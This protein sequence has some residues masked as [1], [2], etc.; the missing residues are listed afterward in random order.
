MRRTG[1]RFAYTDVFSGIVSVPAELFEAAG[2]FDV[3]LD[4]CRDD[5]EL[6]LRLIRGGAEIVF[7]D[8]AGGWHHELRDHERL[9]RRKR[10]EGVADLRL[11]RRHPS[12]WPAL[13]IAW[14]EPP[15]LSRLGVMRRLALDAPL[16]GDLAARA[17]AA[18]LSPLERIRAH[19]TWRSAHAGVM[20]Y[21]Y[22]RGVAQDVGSRGALAELGAWCAAQPS[23]APREIALDLSRGL[24]AAE[25]RLDA[26]RPDGARILWGER[27]IGRIAPRPDAE[28]LRGAHLR[29]IL[30]VEHR[31]R[32]IRELVAAEA[33]GEASA[34]TRPA[35]TRSAVPPG[36]VVTTVAGGPDG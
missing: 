24:D 15:L 23:A 30:W 22:W 4:N 8:D 20:Y 12:L 2:G 14:P 3:A 36:A 16:L 7:R 34:A 33:L 32:L 27:E 35:P 18:M 19:G 21:W 25:R 10:L 5:F 6:G 29:R 17:L 28:P 9:V 11:A 1:H 13:R 26:E 31:D